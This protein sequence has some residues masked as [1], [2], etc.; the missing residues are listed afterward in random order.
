MTNKKLSEGV[1]KKIVEALKKQSEIE[2]NPASSSVALED[3]EEIQPNYESQIEASDLD[4][5][6]GESDAEYSNP[7]NQFSNEESVFEADEFQ[8]QVIPPQPQ[9]S[10]NHAY[11]TN[12]VNAKSSFNDSL[13]NEL[14]NFEIPGNIAVLKKLINQLPTGVNKHTGAQI[15]KQT[16][17]ALGISMK[18][19]LQEAQ[20]VQEGLNNSG[21]ECYNTIQEYKRQILTLEKQAQSYQKQYSA[22]NEL[23]SLFIQTGV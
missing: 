14:D 11:N 22:L 17:E 21:K 1:G 23:I 16:M 6:F 12:N 5:L 20:Q 4:A 8:S 2:I 3:M 7:K 19:V 18:S 9:A 10:M 15:I 13:M